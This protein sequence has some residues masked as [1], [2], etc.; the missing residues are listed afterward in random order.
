MNSFTP[1]AI[2]CA[3]FSVVVIQSTSAA[4]W[5]ENVSAIQQDTYGFSK[6]FSGATGNLFKKGFTIGGNIT[7]GKYYA[8]M[9][10]AEYG[11][12]V[13]AA[14]NG[15][16][17]AS[18]VITNSDAITFRKFFSD[19][20]DGIKFPVWLSIGSGILGLSKKLPSVATAAAVAELATNLINEANKGMIESAKAIALKINPN[21]KFV[22]RVFIELRNGKPYAHLLDSLVV[23]KQSSAKEEVLLQRT[24][25]A[26]KVE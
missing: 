19:L 3:A 20:G 6:T 4:E 25:L 16:E 21:D 18:H 8:V 22:R 26:L 2:V 11:K 12:I 17:W 23:Y 14:N 7:N 13:A 15:V 5:Y 9:K 1:M 10:Q 24:V